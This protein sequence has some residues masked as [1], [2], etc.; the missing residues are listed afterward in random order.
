ML[1]DFNAFSDEDRYLINYYYFN[2]THALL[3]IDSCAVEMQ[4][5]V[6]KG[7]S[8]ILQTLDGRSHRDCGPMSPPIC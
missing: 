7:W 1:H 4:H 6:N 2:E 5:V 8:M 3:Q